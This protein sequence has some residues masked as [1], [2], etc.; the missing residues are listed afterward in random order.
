MV[1]DHHITQDLEDMVA[2]VYN[3]SYLLVG[4]WQ[5][6]LFFFFMFWLASDTCLV[7]LFRMCSLWV[8]LWCRSGHGSVQN[9]TGEALIPSSALS[10][11]IGN[12]SLPNRTDL[13][14][15]CSSQDSFPPFFCGP[16]ICCS[17]VQDVLIFGQDNY[18]AY[19]A[20]LFL[21]K[22]VWIAVIRSRSQDPCETKA[23]CK[24]EC[25]WDCWFSKAVIQLPVQ[26]MDNP[27]QIFKVSTFG[28]FGVASCLCSLPWQLSW[29]WCGVCC[30]L[31]WSSLGRTSAW[32]CFNFSGSIKVPRTS[33]VTVQSQDWGLHSV[34]AN[35]HG[36]S[37][38]VLNI[39]DFCPPLVL[40]A[41]EPA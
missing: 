27:Q 15:M 1:G 13:S 22:L 5:T 41:K 16:W 26:T 38:P 36:L 14:G 39:T 11:V 24:R 20:A 21:L 4:F 28:N 29:L 19:P 25:Y 18:T 33:L 37:F 6:Q 8:L 3:P 32:F 31:S 17:S 30:C 12:P 9:M 10:F 35:S 2:G 7:N 34:C 23:W 40:P